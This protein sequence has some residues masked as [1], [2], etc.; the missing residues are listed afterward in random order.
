MAAIKPNHNNQRNHAMIRVIEEIF[1]IDNVIERKIK[2][3][4]SREASM[5][6]FLFRITMYTNQLA[7][8]RNV[9]KSRLKQCSPRILNN[10]LERNQR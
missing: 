4:N 2:S 10:F 3:I 8:I 7:R 5:R 6:N 9:C 1:I